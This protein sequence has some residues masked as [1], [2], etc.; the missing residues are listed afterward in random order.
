MNLRRALYFTLFRLRG[1]PLGSW[2]ER[3]LR[4]ECDGIP[5]DTTR[6]LLVRLL[7]HCERSVPYY[8]DVM[9]RIGGSYHEDP[10]EY[11]R[12]FPILTR[13]IIRT[14]FDELK[15]ADLHRRHWYVNH[16]G[17]STGEPVRFLQ[18]WEYAACSG[19]ITLLYSK[20]AGREVGECEARLWGSERDVANGKRGWKS[21]LI[22]NL[23]D[24]L[25]LNAYRMSREEMHGFVSVLNARRPKL[26]VAY[27]DA[28]HQLARFCEEEGIEVAGQTPVIT[29]A[30]TLHSFMRERIERVFRCR[31]FN[32]YGSR[33]LG[34]VACEVPGSNGLWVAPWGNYVEIVDDPG[35]RLPEGSEG[36]I[37]VTSLMNYAMPL[38]RY[39]IGDRGV[40]STSRNTDGGSPTRVLKEV[41]G[42]T[43]DMYKTRDGTFVEPGYF[44]SMLYLK[45]WVR[46]F[47][48]IQKSHECIVFRIVRSGSDYRQAELDEISEKTKLVMGGDCETVF[49]FVDDITPSASGKYRYQICELR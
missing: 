13:E 47:Q 5:P 3:F 11:L 40:L 36:E 41:L 16:S 33:E 10:E 32:R 35:N 27:A 15:S 9:R 26:I 39:R 17:G 28:M 8:A 25:F 37:L 20:L 4:E 46:K 18:D 45:A 42:R 38:I 43:A 6:R 29:S 1:L 24:T 30:T 22:N 44:E 19:A 23:S 34:D 48:T 7:E 31:V 2:Y 14:R 21:R 12:H 49:E